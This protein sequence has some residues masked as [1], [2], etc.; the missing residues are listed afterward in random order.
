MI[1]LMNKKERRFFYR[2]VY[3]ILTI[4]TARADHLDDSILQ[5]MQERHI[6]G[7]S[8]AVI[9]DGQILVSKGY[10]VAD[11]EWSSAADVDTSYQI[12]SVT[13]QFTATAVMMLVEEG[14]LSL[15]GKIGQYLTDLPSSWN[16]VTLRQLL[17]HTSGIKSYTGL[18]DFSRIPCK[19]Y[20]KGEA[21]RLVADAPLE[22]V[23]G[24]KW[25][26][27]NSGYYLLGMIIEKISGQD[28]SQFLQERI[29]R[30]LGMLSTR[31]NDLRVIIQK[32]AQGYSWREGNW[33]HGQPVSPTQPWAAGALIST[34]SDM[35]RWDSALSASRLLKSA[36]W[37][38]MWIP[39]RLADG[40]LKNYGFAW[41]VDTIDGHR[42]IAHD[43]GIDG[44]SSYLARWI[45]DRLTVI[46]LTN[47]EGN[48]AK[49]IA[50]RLAEQFLPGFSEKP[51]SAK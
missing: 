4:M 3:L 11:L 26:Y 27:S 49:A 38:R 48:H 21:I 45:D 32:R 47:L 8:L 9:K 39:T 43:G 35:V 5:M 13:K 19:E 31:V 17:N 16:G 6:P 15:D 18:P 23:P 29:F 28:Y 20:L 22:F 14:K 42:R 1:H 7:I 24:E 44:F 2:I 25:Q 51:V 36:S 50:D 46:V 40:S 41:R 37:Q 30:P 10:G 12:A 33:Y 34:V